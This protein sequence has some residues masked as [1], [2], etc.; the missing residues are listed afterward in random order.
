MAFHV[1][2]SDTFSTEG[3][4]ILK[5]S[6]DIELDYRPGISAKE[7]L[8]HI[9]NADALIVRGGTA[10]TAQLIEAGEKLKII[11]RA[12]IGVENIDITAANRRGIVVTNTPTGS[13]TTMA[14]HAMA[15]MLALARKIPQA[16]HAVKQGKW[17]SAAFH[18]SDI[19][20]KTLGIIGGGKIAR[21][22]IEYAHALHMN[23]NLYDPYLSEEVIKRLGARKVSFDTLLQNADFLTL[24]VPLNMET[25]HMLNA[26]TFARLKRGCLLINCALG[27][28]INERDLIRA[29]DEGIVGG[30][31]L[32]TFETEPP[33]PDNPLLSRDNVICTPHLRAATVD[34]QINV[35][36]QAAHQVINFLRSGVVHNALNVPSINADLLDSL[37]PY[38]NLAER[39][40]SFLSQL[41][42][43]PFSSI[44]VEFFGDIIQHPTEP[45][46][47]A[48]LKGL[49]T[50]LLGS[51]INYVNAPH[52]VRERGISVTETRT[53]IAEG[54]SNMIRLHVCGEE[55]EQSISGALFGNNESRIVAI[56]EYPVECIPE[57]DILVV[58]NVDRPG[59][60]ALLGT[61][62]A[63]KNVNV[64]MMNLSRRKI[65]GKALSLLTVDQAV[66][67]AAIS[68][69]LADER[70]LSARQVS[71]PI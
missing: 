49:L 27:G 3:L 1:L 70:I 35:T 4:T 67:D 65:S 26:K 48:A 14:E 16:C 11:A 17:S 33:S 59:V 2:V 56:D 8:H 13:T 40:G 52:I 44:R 6:G 68:Q 20:G 32:D 12:G 43:K 71:M 64:A 50:P 36:C 42:R 66:P 34:A 39:L 62:L 9:P 25:E 5:E 41:L 18:G 37:R 19:Y 61:V 7:L 60:L 47:M 51:R 53:N 29:L 54:F 23:I 45:L 28:L 55:G 10:V 63:E 46:T 69:L 57:G 21:R 22:V 31:A 15:M 24:H 38:L 58:K 30:A